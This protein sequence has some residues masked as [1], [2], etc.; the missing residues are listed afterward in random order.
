MIETEIISILK[1]LLLITGINLLVTLAL[2]FGLVICFCLIRNLRKKIKSNQS[3]IQGLELSCNRLIQE[4]LQ[5]GEVRA[6]IRAFANK[7]N[8]D[9]LR[10][11]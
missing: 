2:L 5:L 8:I 6:K 7:F 3:M 11:I 10:D 4:F 9:W 1:V